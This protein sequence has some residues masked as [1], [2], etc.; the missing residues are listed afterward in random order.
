LV[1]CNIMCCCCCCWCCCWCSSTKCCPGLVSWIELNRNVG[2]ITMLLRIELN[3]SE[4]TWS[5]L[6]G[7]PVAHGALATHRVHVAH[8]YLINGL[9]TSIVVCASALSI[10][11][12]SRHGWVGG[13]VR[14]L[15]HCWA[16]VY[17]HAIAASTAALH[18]C[19]DTQLITNAIT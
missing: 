13:N 14:L 10:S 4:F 3:L 16:N 18:N 6:N 7:S 1:W 11:S 12:G 8:W 2:M 19:Y 17:I 5:E 15:P 9:C